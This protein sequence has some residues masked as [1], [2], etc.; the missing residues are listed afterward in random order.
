[1]FELIKESVEV[2]VEDDLPTVVRTLTNTI[3]RRNGV[4]VLDLIRSVSATVP[5]H[6]QTIIVDILFNSFRV[7][8]QAVTCFLSSLRSAFSIKSIVDVCLLLLLLAQRTQR[9]VVIDLLFRLISLDR[10]PQ[11]QMILCFKEV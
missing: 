4:A 5:S 1:M 10:I 7:N 8:I 6:I 9:E 11:E 3:T 2:A